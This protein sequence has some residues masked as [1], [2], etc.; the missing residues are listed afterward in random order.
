MGRT[1]T[2]R[3]HSR[4]RMLYLI[5]PTNTITPQKMR[6]FFMRIPHSVQSFTDFLFML[7]WFVARNLLALCTRGLVKQTSKVS[8][9]DGLN[10]FL[11]FTLC[12]HTSMLCVFVMLLWAFSTI[13]KMLKSHWANRETS[14]FPL[15]QSIIAMVR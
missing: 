1:S 9:A 2:Y 5:V 6:S 14:L 10:T 8:D 7:P 3:F 12:Q 13:W 15:I 4:Y 11:E